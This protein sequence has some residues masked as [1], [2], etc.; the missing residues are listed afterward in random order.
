MVPDRQKVWTDVRNGRTDDAITLSLRLLR[1]IKNN[2]CGCQK[3]LAIRTDGVSFQIFLA[4]F[5]LTAFL[6]NHTA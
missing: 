5:A 2:D 1:G 3:S 4:C 6:G